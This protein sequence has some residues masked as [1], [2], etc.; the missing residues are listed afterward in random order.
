MWLASTPVAAESVATIFSHLAT[1]N[2]WV[3]SS[4][5]TAHAATTILPPSAPPPLPLPVLLLLLLLLLSIEVDVMVVVAIVVAVV[6]AVAV[7]GTSQLIPQLPLAP[8]APPPLTLLLPPRL[9]L[10]LLLLALPRLPTYTRNLQR[11]RWPLPLPLPLPLL[12]LLFVASAL[13]LASPI[14]A[15]PDNRS[16]CCCDSPVALP[17]LS[18]LVLLYVPLDNLASPDPGENSSRPGTEKDTTNGTEEASEGVA[19]KGDSDGGDSK[20][21][22]ANPPAP[23]L[24]LMSTRAK[25][26]L[27]TTARSISHT[28]RVAVTTPPEPV[29]ALVPPPLPLLP[30]LL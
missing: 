24:M 17:V 8:R 5:T 22:A 13:H 7:G 6:V 21:S 12:L 15:A 28:T 14:T 30:P 9:L 23:A 16:C 1:V 20:G 3:V 18:L 25:R 11:R 4:G 27:P 29:P 19:E 26:V 10:V 2:E